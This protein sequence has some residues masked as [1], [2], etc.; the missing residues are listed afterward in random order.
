[1]PAFCYYKMTKSKRR[2]KRR[3]DLA[4]K[5]RRKYH[6]KGWVTGGALRITGGFVTA[7][8]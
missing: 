7:H 6:P 3:L 2:L 5:I 1:M 4:N 8:A